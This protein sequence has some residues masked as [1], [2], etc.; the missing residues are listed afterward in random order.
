MLV[1]ECKFAN[2]DE[3]IIDAL[4]FGSSSQRVQSRLLEYNETL[5]LN[6]AID[7]ARTEEATS[8][9]LQDIRGTTTIDSL[10]HKN[11][12]RPQALSKQRKE[13]CGNCGTLH[14][15]SQKS[16]CPAFGTKCLNCGKFNHWRKVCRS[17]KLKG[18]QRGKHNQET[19]KGKPVG[20]RIP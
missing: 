2:A 15:R 4:I 8:T 20:E 14:D 1:N 11:N 18:V 3:N 19:R 7:I 6:K 17:G 12:R 13:T 16:S 10:R 9:Q 5:T